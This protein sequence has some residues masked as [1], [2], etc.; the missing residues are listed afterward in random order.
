MTLVAL[1][2]LVAAPPE[3]AEPPAPAITPVQGDVSVSFG[4]ADRDP[5]AGALYL[6]GALGWAGLSGPAMFGGGGVELTYTAFA[7]PY[8]MSLG[9]QLRG[10]LVWA[11]P[12]ANPANAIPDL[13]VYVRVTPFGGGVTGPVTNAAGT[14]TMVSRAFFGVRAGLGVT[15]LWPVRELYDHFPLFEVEGVGGQVLE[16]LSALVLFPLA[17]LNHGEVAFEYV[18]AQAPL[19]AVIFRVGAGF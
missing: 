6:G 10:G 5:L 1:L 16:V 7:D 19:T 13:L 11:R 12:G 18:A 8:R 2:L 4:I 9:V 14:T 17:V 3:P 15:A